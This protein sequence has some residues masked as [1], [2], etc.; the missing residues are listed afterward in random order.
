MTS[1]PSPGLP[2][3]P[4]QTEKSKRYDRQLRLWGDH[5]Q[6]A[7]ER[8]NVCLVNATAVGTEILKSLVLP[9]LGAFT[10]LDPHKVEGQ[11]AGNNFFLDQGCIGSSRG[12]V[13]MRLLLEM[14]H[15]VRGEFVEESVEQI[16]ESNPTFFNSFSLVITCGLPE[17]P[18]MQLAIKLYKAGVPLLVVNTI[19]FL[20]YIRLQIEEHVVVESH[21]DESMPDLRLDQP[22]SELDTWL[23]QEAARM[24]NMTRTD[25]GHTPYPVILYDFLRKWKT[26]HN[27]NL[28]LKY[29]EKKELKSVISQG[30]LMKEN[31][32]EIPEDE[33]NFAEAGT[34]VNTVVRVSRIP[35]NTQAILQD[36]AAKQLTQESSA[37]WIMA[38]AVKDF[39][40]SKEEGNGL[41]PVAGNIPDMF[42]DSARYIQLQNIYRD[43]ANSDA[44]A[45]YRRVQQTLESLGRST[46]SISETEVKR[47]CKESANLR[48]IRGSSLAQETSGKSNSNFSS[49]LEDPDSDAIYYLVLK[50]AERYTSEH[51]AS[52]GNAS[53]DIESDIGLLKS[54]LTKLATEA[55]ITTI[56]PGQYDE[57]IH[58]VSRY[59]GCELHSISAFLG[60]VA[61]HEGIKL[62]TKQ[63]VPIDNVVVYNAMTS[64]TSNFKV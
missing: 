5:G 26:D 47:F 62:L 54:C 3:S 59:G 2:N 39:V 58:E 36:D 53:N 63:Y 60:G 7:L 35:S 11:D 43:R 32:P 14:N 10:I 46:D 61:A 22:W 55:G 27:G 19:G 9:G 21:P 23:S 57:H 31:H 56:T 30:V 18:L 1:T 25:H 50:A 51:G 45:V 42:S 38:G 15:D 52:P 28:P 16:L 44:E 13:T 37:F 33:E 17:R 34:A 29:S 49:N 20:G 40:A 8:S 12:E 6:S 24:A 64:T 4:H 41:L 48:L